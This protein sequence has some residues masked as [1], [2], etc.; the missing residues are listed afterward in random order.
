VLVQDYIPGESL[1]DRLERGQRFTATVIRTIAQEVLEIL[2]YLHELSPPVLHRDIKPSNLIINSENNVYL[3]DFGAVQSRGAVT[4]V[5]F[6]VVGTSGYAPLEQFWG[7]AVPSSDLYALGMTLIHLLTGIV[8]IE[9]P[10]RDSKIQFRQLVTIDDDLIDWLE[11]M[12][13][14]AVEKRFKSAREALKFLQHPYYRQASSLIDP[15]KLPKPPHS[16]IR[17]AK[18]RDNL[19]INLPPKIKLP[20]DAPTLWSLAIVLTVTVFISPILTFIIALIGFICLREM[21][22]ILTPQEVLIKYKVL[23]FIYQKFAF[24][25]QDLWGIFL[26]SNGTE[27]NYQIRLR[28]AKNY[29]LIG[30]NLREDECLWLGQEIQDWLNFIKYSVSPQDDV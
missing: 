1:S 23:I 19:E 2:I 17:I 27:G 4:G 13:D 3:V 7:R 14:V 22:L 24:R 26:H 18:H 15:K 29:Y 28:T 25:T 16:S 8:P 21:Q 5:T 10:H 30:Q 12:T 6:T 11:T 9:L 20:S